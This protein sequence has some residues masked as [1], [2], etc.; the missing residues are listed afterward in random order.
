M[1]RW[2]VGSSLQYRFLVIAIALVVMF[3]GFTRLR[4]VPVDVFP[5]F[6]PPLVEIQTEALGLS[7]DEVE[8]LITLNLEEFLS[9]TSWLKTIRSESIPGLSSI[10]LI[11]EPGTD[12]MRARQ[13]VQERLSLAYTLPNVSKPP[14]ML[15]PL[16]A[17]NRVMMVGLSS[18]ELSPIQMSVLARWTIKPRLMG[19]PGVANVVIWGQRKRQLQVQIDPERL[20]ANGVTQ[21]QIIRTTGDALWVSPLSFLNA[22]MPG[23]GGWIDTPNQRLGIRHILPI[24]SPEDLARIPVHGS[25]M[26]LG[27]VADVVEG[28]PPLIGDAFL[29]GGPGIILVVEK[30]PGVNTLEV[31]RGVEEALD[32][33]QAGLPGLEVDTTIFRLATYIEMAMYNLTMTLIISAVLVVLVL[34]AFLYDWRVTLISLVAIP[35]S[36]MAAM[37]VLYLRGASV[38]TMVLAG[39]GIALGVVV[40]DAIIDIENIVRRLRQYWKEGSGKSTATIILEASLE[41]RGA[42]VYATLIIVLAVFPVFFM[43][44]VSGA[45]FRPFALSY[46]LALLA[47]MV[48][49]LTVTPA[50]ALVLLNKE[51]LNRRESPLVRWLQNGYDRGLSRIIKTPRIA[52]FTAGALMLV[53]LAV[54]PFLGQSLLPSF[55]ERNLLI[56][57]DGPPGTSHSEMSRIMIRVIQ[58]LKSIPGVHKVGA[59]IGRAV[60]GDQVVGIN[61]GQIWVSIDPKASYDATVETVRKVIDGYHGLDRDVHTYLKERIREVLAGASEAIVVRL[62]GPEREILRDKAEEVRQVLSEIDGIIDLEVE[63]QIEEPHVEIKVDIAKAKPYGIK[64]GDVRRASAT[65]F[66]GIEAGNLFEEQ[67]VFNVVVWGTPKTRHS[68]TSIEEL[69]IDT[70]NGGHVRLGDVA[71]V[72]VMPTPTVIKHEAISPR[73]DVVANVRGR[74]L[75]TVTREVERRLKEVEFPLEYHPELL[76]EY[77]ERQAAQNRLLVV[78]VV[79]AIG[80]YLL[81]QASFESWRLASLAFLALPTALVGSVL[82]AFV[83]GCMISLG[84]LVGFL[85]VLGIAARNGIMLINHYQHLQRHEGEIFGSGLVLRG[86]RERLAPI[87]MTAMTTALALLPFVLFG[88][89]AGL[90]IEHPM[91]TVILGGLVTSTLLNMFIIPPLYLFIA[92]SR[93]VCDKVE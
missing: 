6:E 20:R 75:G 29:N 13:L 33:L 54:W 60:T 90:E 81:L 76:G 61:S 56:E 41:V 74:D 14:I 7:A 71:D 79:A 89:I 10:L 92:G 32:A 18:K 25:T 4:N 26:R 84:S 27:D 21:E 42:I 2:I 44:G 31:T 73:I 34:G 1:I 38:N 37:L 49:A 72:R 5:E 86:A 22:S 64:P 85:A 36:L 57:M 51:P 59:H 55:K 17:T 65:I 82:A 77:V 23:T 58:E 19:V 91:A 53:S 83:D 93:L 50:L 63:G 47:S 62:Y 24:S 9:G 52:F 70:P 3:F 67:K 69:L 88:E 48:I 87:L 15:Q 68:L 66:A 40:D 39:F 8:S 46:V 45:F 43:S 30:F 12:V 78:A 11:F 16:S 28:H 80:I 35:L